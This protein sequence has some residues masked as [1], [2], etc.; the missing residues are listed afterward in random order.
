M[1]S[2]PAGGYGS[3]GRARSERTFERRERRLRPGERL[4]LC[5]TG[6]SERRTEDG[7]VVSLEGIARAVERAGDRSAAATVR[8]IQEAVTS[9]SNEPLDDDAA[10]LVLTVR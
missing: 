10:A 3:L 5:T 1:S 2:S 4:T 6:V 7:G 9:A 8:Y